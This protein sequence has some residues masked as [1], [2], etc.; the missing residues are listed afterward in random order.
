MGALRT[1]VTRA[2]RWVFTILRAALG[3]VLLLVLKN[4][5]LLVL[6]TSVAM[7]IALWPVIKPRQ[8]TQPA[9]TQTDG[10]SGL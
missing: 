4:L 8:G 10:G 5:V 3:L 9:D 7:L 6:G 1:G 2:A